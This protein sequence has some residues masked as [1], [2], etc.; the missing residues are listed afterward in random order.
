MKMKTYGGPGPRESGMEAPPRVWARVAHL[1]DRRRTVLHR[2]DLLTPYAAETI[3]DD[4]LRAG[5][6]AELDLT[7]AAGTSAGAL[8]LVHERFAALEHRG[9]RVS[10]RRESPGR[11]G[12]SVPAARCA[13]PAHASVR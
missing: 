11:A 1:R 7:V 2:A 8:A 12:A 5:D 13:R 10:V 9:I 4:A 6:G 3:A